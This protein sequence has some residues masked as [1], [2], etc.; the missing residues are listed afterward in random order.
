MVL[1]L[2][3]PFVQEIYIFE[4][5]G[6]FKDETP[7]NSMLIYIFWGLKMHPSPNKKKNVPITEVI[8][9]I[10]FHSHSVFTCSKLTIE[11]SKQGVK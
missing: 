7:I 9:F 3:W 2:E 5:L 1:A 4:D 11:T 6:Q 8:L 10:L